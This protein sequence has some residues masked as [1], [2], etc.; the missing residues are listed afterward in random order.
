[1]AFTF[2][3]FLLFNAGFEGLDNSAS[4]DSDS[5][6][7]GLGLKRVRSDPNG[8]FLDV[9]VG[10]GWKEGGWGRNSELEMMPCPGGR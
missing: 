10:V 5:S 9:E 7:E 4:S 6:V 2:E 1:L 3:D 8:L